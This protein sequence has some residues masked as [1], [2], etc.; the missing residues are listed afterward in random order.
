MAHIEPATTVRARPA[1]I[2]PT[3]HAML[4]YGQS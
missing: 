3:Q 2:S 1:V 4:D